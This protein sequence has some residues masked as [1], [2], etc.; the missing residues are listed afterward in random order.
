MAVTKII[1]KGVLGQ[2]VEG[3]KML[4][5]DGNIRYEYLDEMLHD[6]LSQ[7]LVISLEEPEKE[8]DPII[9][10]RLKELVWPTK[11]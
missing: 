3:H 9:S 4:R 11:A 10:K 2:D 8:L 7:T 1:A 6:Y 5:R